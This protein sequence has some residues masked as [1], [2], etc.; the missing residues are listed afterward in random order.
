MKNN[1]YKFMSDYTFLLVCLFVLVLIV[2]TI[3]KPAMFWRM[4]SWRAMTMQFPE[5]GVFALG[6]MLCFIIGCIDV[7]FV[8][9]GNFATVIACRFMLH[10]KGNVPDEQIGPV[11]I[12]AILIAL[13]VGALG[14]YLNGNLISRLGI[15]PILATLSTQLVFSGLSIALTKGNAVTGIPEVYS[16]VGHMNLFGFLPVPL[17]V[18]LIVFLICAFLL[19]YTIYGRKLYMIGANRKVA[20]FSAINTTGIINTT[21][22]INGMFAAVGALIMVSTMNSAKADYGSSYLMRCILILVLAGVLPAGGMGK[23]RNV[24]ISVV[25]IQIIS[26]GVNM[27]SQINAFYSNL[28]SAILLLVMLVATSYLLGEKKLRKMDSGDVSEN[29]A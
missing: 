26:S 10:Y 3:L 5:Y 24:L 9:L 18:F 19:K 29:P 8:A 11:I 16:R 7:S 21:F 28:I 14:G 4:P 17:F 22:I 6:V 15:P 27:F 12:V 2:F 1:K 23:I 13:A 25:I 20:R